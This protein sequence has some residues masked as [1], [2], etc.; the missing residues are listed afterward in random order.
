MV[1]IKSFRALRPRSDRVKEVASYPYDVINSDEARKIAEGN[2]FS[3]LHI[4]KPEIDLAPSV[5]L[6]D[7][8]V[9][10]KAQENFEYFQK[11]GTLIEE[12]KYCLY[13][14][15]QVMGN[16]EQYG[17][18]SSC[19]VDDYDSDKIKKHEKTR[20]DKE[21]DRTRHVLTLNANAGPIFLTYPDEK[22]VDQVIQNW[23]TTHDAQYDFLADD[24]IQH[25]V[26]IID[27]KQ[28]N[29]RLIQLFEK[30]PH[31]YVA[32]GHHRSASASRA[33]EIRKNENPNHTGSEEYNFFLA[34]LFP[35]SQ[36]KILAYNRAIQDLNGLD[37]DQILE[38]LSENFMVHESSEKIP[39]HAKTF[40][41]YLDKTWYSL[42]AKDNAYDPNDVIARL[43][44]SIL[45]DKVLAPLFDIQDPRTSK[46]ID[47]IGGIRGP[48]ELERLVNQGSHQIA[49]S[50]FPCSTQ[51]LM[52]IANAGEIMP[53][54]ST[55]FEPKLRSGLLV[56]KI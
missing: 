29:D 18:V 28:I 50:L 5:D 38:K 43:D 20:P 31:S 19:A 15:R 42:K 51:D 4:V 44:V 56:K 27:D 9:Y 45:Q 11:S 47:F 40:C 34:V 16:H 6:Y 36:L 14:Y 52:D 1:Q 25:T 48:E 39:N 10:Q 8:A 53:P 33:R 22:E 46:N 23:V 37:P 3:F 12:E 49:F 24:Q 17:L 30:I 32:D 55:W 54:K 7:D 2:P 13:I 41:M 35:A 26:W 21:N